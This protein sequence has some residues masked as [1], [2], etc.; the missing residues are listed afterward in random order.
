MREPS[1]EH[2]KDIEMCHRPAVL[3][4]VLT[5]AFIERLD[6]C[7]NDTLSSLSTSPEKEDTVVTDVPFCHRQPSVTASDTV[8][9]VPLPLCHASY[10]LRCSNLQRD[11][12]DCANCTDLPTGSPLSRQ[13]L[14]CPVDRCIV[15]H[16]KTPEYSED[17]M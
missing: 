12:T 10:V 14:R 15:V 11:C 4:T 13:Q 3:R 5:D 9:V 7:S 1:T 8:K 17:V 2:R 6:V 16:R